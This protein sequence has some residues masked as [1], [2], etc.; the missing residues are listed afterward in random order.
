MCG[1]LK[2]RDSF[3]IRT[4]AAGGVSNLRGWK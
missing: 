3:L 1:E 4:E 2:D